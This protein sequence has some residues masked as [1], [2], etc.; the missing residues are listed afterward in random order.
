ML[1]FE[2]QVPAFRLHGNN[3]HA[4]GPRFQIPK[5]SPSPRAQEF[6]NPR[7]HVPWS[8]LQAP[9]SSTKLRKILGFASQPA[10]PR[11]HDPYPGL[12]ILSSQISGS[13]PRPRSQVEVSCNQILRTNL[14]SQFQAAGSGRSFRRLQISSPMPG[15]PGVKTQSPVAGPRFQDP[16]LRSKSPVPILQ[17][18]TLV[19]FSHVSKPTSQA[20]V[21]DLGSLFPGP[22]LLGAKSKV[23]Q[24]MS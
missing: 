10:K 15:G 6:L 1:I 17:T 19:R 18:I 3:H 16:S 11:F 23:P 5:R 21:P 2:S 24:I 12:A 9:G 20:Q 8:G 14:R 13:G 22:L 4:P 7:P